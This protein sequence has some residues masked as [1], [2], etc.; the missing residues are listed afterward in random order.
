[1]RTTLTENTFYSEHPLGGANLER[2]SRGPRSS[3]PHLQRS[4]SKYYKRK[5]L[6]Q[7]TIASSAAKPSLEITAGICIS[8]E[9]AFRCNAGEMQSLGQKPAEF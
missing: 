6:V 9:F 3:Q 1:M 2:I 5:Q 8:L 7:N 4:L